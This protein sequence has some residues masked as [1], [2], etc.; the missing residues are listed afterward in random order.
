TL[1][2]STGLLTT[3]RLRMNVWDVEFTDDVRL[4]HWVGLI[5][6]GVRYAHLSQEYAAGTTDLTLGGSET[7]ISA[8]N[9]NGAGPTLALEMHRPLGGAGLYFY[10]YGRGSV[11]FGSSKESTDI[12]STASLDDFLGSFS[13]TTQKNPVLPVG[14][15]DFGLGWNRSVSRAVLYAQVGFVGQ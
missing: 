8:H 10:G 6:L 15:I 11:L 14:E 3:A 13:G 9:F 12:L 1:G 4:S 7:I 5:A 2:G